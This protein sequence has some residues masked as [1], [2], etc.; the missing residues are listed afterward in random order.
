MKLAEKQYRGFMMMGNKNC[1]SMHC[2][3]EK[4]HGGTMKHHNNNNNKMLNNTSNILYNNHN[5]SETYKEPNIYSM[6]GQGSN[7]K[8]ERNSNLEKLRQTSKKESKNQYI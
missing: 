7:N 4:C 6:N 8:L 5:S 3:G 2:I 1:K